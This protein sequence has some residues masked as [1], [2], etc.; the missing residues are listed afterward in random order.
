MVVIA[1]GVNILVYL[2]LVPSINGHSNL[3]ILF[4]TN[5]V[6]LGNGRTVIECPHGLHDIV[7]MP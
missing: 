1:L 4:S 2:D 3:H 7:I 5:C 6:G